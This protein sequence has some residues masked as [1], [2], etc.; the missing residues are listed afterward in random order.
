MA[1]NLLDNFSKQH[2]SILQQLFSL[3][4]SML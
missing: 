2:K 1:Q 4:K 3:T